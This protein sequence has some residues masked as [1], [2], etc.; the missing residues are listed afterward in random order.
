MACLVAGGFA[1]AAE[2]TRN[3]GPAQL[4]LPPDSA[5]PVDPQ[6]EQRPIPCDLR[7]SPDYV[8][9]IDAGGREVAPAD[10]PSG[11]GVEINTEMFVEVRPQDRRLRGT[12]VIVNLP[13]LGAPAC[14]PVN[15]T[16][17]K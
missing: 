12:G 9:G 5:L 3:P 4:T 7:A 15:K 2:P 16:P 10:V 14:V 13:G 8:A 6:L 1:H 17:R 11:Q